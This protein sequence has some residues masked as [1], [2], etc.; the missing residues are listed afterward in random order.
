MIRASL[1][2]LR[3]LFA[4]VLYFPIFIRKFVNLLVFQ[5]DNEGHFLKE[6]RTF[7]HPHAASTANKLGSLAPHSSL[8]P[9]TT[10][11]PN[12]TL[13]D[14]SSPGFIRKERPVKY[15]EPTLILP[16]TLHYQVFIIHLSHL[17]FVKKSRFTS[18]ISQQC[19]FL[20]TYFCYRWR[21]LIESHSRVI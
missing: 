7:T 16:D 19:W 1:C 21:L 14:K 4:F 10:H 13:D 6:L 9:G 2:P 15:L 18:T 20:S 3:F 12:I 11:I 5:W 17:D 8:V